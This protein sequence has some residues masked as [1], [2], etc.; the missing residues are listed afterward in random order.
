M[1]NDFDYGGALQ[2]A[3]SLLSQSTK[4]TTADT[5][6]S[7]LNPGQVELGPEYAR[8]ASIAGLLKPTMGGGYFGNV[9]NQMDAE[10]AA[11]LEQA[12]LRAMYLPAIANAV[13]A[14]QQAA[15]QV[16]DV[17]S[18]AALRQ[19]QAIQ[20]AQKQ[21]L[22]MPVAEAIAQRIQQR[23]GALPGS[24]P[25]TMGALSQVAAPAGGSGPISPAEIGVDYATAPFFKDYLGLDYTDALKNRYTPFGRSG[26]LQDNWSPTHETVA[27]NPAMLR[28][29][30]RAT[31]LGKADAE[32]QTV[33]D[34]NGNAHLVPKSSVVA[35]SVAASGATTPAEQAIV[36]TESGGNGSAVSPK[37]AAGAWQVMP[38][39]QADPGFGVTPAKDNSPEELNRVGKDYY[40]AMV[41]RYK[42]PTLGA[43][44]YNMGPARTDAWIAKGAQWEK[45]PQETRDY[46]GKVATLTAVN[47]QQ[48]QDNA[49]APANDLSNTPLAKPPIGTEG[50]V[51]QMQ[52]KWDTLGKQNQEAQNTIS[53]LQSIR[54]LAPK[55]LTGQF[56]DRL[57]YV[58][59]LLAP[60]NQKASD[61]VTATNLLNKYGSQIVTRLSQGGMS[62][63][64]ARELLAAANP[65]SHMTSDAINEATGN[66]IGAQQQLQAKSSLLAQHYKANNPKGYLDAEMK[67]DQSADPRIWQ[68]MNL[69]QQNPAQAKAFAQRLYKQDP[70]FPKRL[71]TLEQLGVFGKAN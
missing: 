54:E 23:M 69:K 67:F 55:A 70:S 24:Q 6:T 37:G 11:E 2:G 63:D 4:P 53:Y 18:Q 32:P 42:D 65:G 10:N 31:E 17:N 64:A 34:D 12:K 15:A 1:P 41:S 50:Q 20:A 30:T 13:T 57:Q 28:Q 52:A 33:Y 22:G 62:T 21:R 45:L 61:Q 38:N 44:A 40:T 48:S 7:Y 36:Q 43:I 68:Y 9:A 56:T 8:R 5:D 3:L 59:S 16:N 35:P 14:R 49:P 58:N 71:A 19:L 51:K 26:L 47:G 46:V 25:Q 60:F 66:I 27:P 29:Q 39:T